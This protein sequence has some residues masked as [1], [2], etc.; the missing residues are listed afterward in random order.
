[1]SEQGETPQAAPVEGAA[2]ETPRGGPGYS[3]VSGEE[4]DSAKRTLPPAGIVVLGLGAV[5]LVL[6]I[7]AF[8]QKPHPPGRGVL[9]TVNAVAINGGSAVLVLANVQ[10]TNGDKS[11]LWIKGLRARLK[12]SAGEWTDVAASPADF[13]RY[14]E[15]FP[16]LA[17]GALKPLEVETKIPPGGEAQGSVIFSF[18]VTAEKFAARQSFQV[19]IQPYDMHELVLGE[20]ALEK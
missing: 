16:A 13:A 14:F 15:A 5:L 18:P 20:P 17:K 2:A 8:V 10:F 9:G 6:A 1:M 19:T 11:R 3:P 12:T 4:F 7:F